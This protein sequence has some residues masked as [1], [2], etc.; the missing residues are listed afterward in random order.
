MYSELSHE[1]EENKR[2]RSPSVDNMM[3]VEENPEDEA[4]GDLQ[5]QFNSLSL[6][7]IIMMTSGQ[8]KSSEELKLEYSEE[9]LISFQEKRDAPIDDK[10]ILDSPEL[11]HLT[12]THKPMALMNTL[13]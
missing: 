10:S 5:A 2:A 6:D 4:V 3:N 12:K 9:Q 13:K 7:Q 1:M 8:A 11:N